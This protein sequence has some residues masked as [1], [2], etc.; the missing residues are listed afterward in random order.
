MSSK[1]GDALLM[2]SYFVTWLSIVILDFSRT[3]NV[4]QNRGEI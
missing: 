1:F 3:M 2:T 4:K